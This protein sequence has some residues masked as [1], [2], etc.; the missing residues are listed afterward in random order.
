MNPVSNPLTQSV[1]CPPSPDELQQFAQQVCHTL[2]AEFA[3]PEVVRGFASF[4]ESVARAW[5]NNLNRKQRPEL[6]GA[7]D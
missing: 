4:V 6:D 7:T 1:Y 2:G 3:D 5:A